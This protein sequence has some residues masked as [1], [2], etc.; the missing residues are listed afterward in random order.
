MRRL[1]CLWGIALV[2]GCVD[3]FP[4]ISSAEPRIRP[5]APEPAPEWDGGRPDLPLPPADARVGQPEPEPE[6]APQP[7]PR[8]EPEPPPDDAA[9]DAGPPPI[10]RG[11]P[12]LD[13]GP[14]PPPRTVYRSV[15]TGRDFSCALRD[16]DGRVICWGDNTF[17][18]LNTPQQAIAHFGLGY[19]HGCAWDAINAVVRCWGRNDAG[20]ANPETINWFGVERFVGGDRTTCGLLGGGFGCGGILP[21]LEID[22]PY[23]SVAVCERHAC[24]HRLNGDDILCW[25]DLG[26][27]RGRRP[28]GILFKPSTLVGSR[29]QICGL[30]L[31]NGISCWGPGP[32]AP[33][34][35]FS[36]VFPSAGDHFCAIAVDGDV[37]C[38]G[39]NAFG[40]ATPPPGI[41]FQQLAGGRAHTCGLD[42]AGHVHCWGR[43]DRGQ[44]DVP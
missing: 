30:N 42:N 27:G 9:L 43:N 25:G 10:D 36:K 31:I 18:Q 3:D 16:A 24:A 44:T 1:A 5:P 33:L 35:F 17:G 13:R 20:Q 14:P 26:E 6:P 38:W 21:R 32:Q 22:R 40:Q 4:E 28:A 23:G 8:P 11:P 41:T 19:E 7:A 39:D 15:A 34:G 37:E 29:A 2:A 12:P